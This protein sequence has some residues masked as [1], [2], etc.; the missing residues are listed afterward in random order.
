MISTSIGMMIA[1]ILIVGMIDS[2]DPS[3]LGN[4]NTVVKLLNNTLIF[5]TMLKK[6]NPDLMNNVLNDSDLLKLA[7]PLN[8]SDEVNATVSY[9]KMGIDYNALTASTSSNFFF[10]I[11]GVMGAALNF[12]LVFSFAPSVILSLFKVP[13]LISILVSII[14][15]TMWWSAI[16]GFIRSGIF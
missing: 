15:Q 2:I 9:N 14:W 11:F 10:N 13:I 4:D 16:I 3:Y 5:N 12:L 1:L 8:N 7:S 6:F